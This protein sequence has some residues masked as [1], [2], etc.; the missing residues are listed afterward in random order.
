MAEPW[1]TFGSDEMGAGCGERDACEFE[2][3]MDLG[4][5]AGTRFSI[6]APRRIQPLR[7]DRLFPK[8]EE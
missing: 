2:L 3:L 6:V 7:N 1:T 5:H 8:M 4:P